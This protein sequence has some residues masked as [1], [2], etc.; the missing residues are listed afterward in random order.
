MRRIVAAAGA[1][2]AMMLA[3]ACILADH[4]TR[5]IL[6]AASR[7]ERG[8]TLHPDQ[9]TL[10]QVPAADCL[11]TAIGS[12]DDWTAH[13]GGTAI[14]AIDI[15]AG[16][17]I[18]PAMIRASPVTPA[19]HTV[20]EVR[21]AS[22]GTTLTP[23]DEIALASAVGCADDA[24]SCLICDHAIVMGTDGEYTTVALDADDALRIM[25][26]QEAGAIVAVVS[27]AR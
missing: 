15:E 11:G 17:P 6:V 20:I 16:Q 21:L 24:R 23:G 10:V 8:A 9:L 14:A 25:A 4:E 26:S 12:W 13:H 22:D 2:L 1:A 27:D 18:L 5:P 19:G 7:I 3:L